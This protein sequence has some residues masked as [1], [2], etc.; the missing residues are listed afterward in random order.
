MDQRFSVFGG[1]IGGTFQFAGAFG[2]FDRGSAQIRIETDRDE[3][4]AHAKC[5]CGIRI[6]GSRTGFGMR[7]CRAVGRREGL[8]RLS[9]CVNVDVAVARRLVR[10]ARRVKVREA[11]G[12]AAGQRR[13]IRSFTGPGQ[14]GPLECGKKSFVFHCAIAP[15]RAPRWQERRRLFSAHIPGR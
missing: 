5:L 6:P 3:I 1:A 9:G 4:M 12:Y 10:A 14:S 13:R 2:V 15:S 8:A 11:R 7:G